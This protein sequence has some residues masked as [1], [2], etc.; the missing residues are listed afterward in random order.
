MCSQVVHANAPKYDEVSVKNLYDYAITLPNMA[1]Y[2]P[3]SFPKGR[4]CDRNYMWTVWNTIH[5]EQVAAALKTARQQRY[6]LENED[7]E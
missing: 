5:P 1:Q 4:Q 3:D 7:V 6:G 2:F